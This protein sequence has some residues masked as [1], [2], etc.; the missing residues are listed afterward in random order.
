MFQKYVQ[1]STFLELMHS[2]NPILKRFAEPREDVVTDLML[3]NQHPSMR[4]RRSSSADGDRGER[5]YLM[6]L[7]LLPGLKN[8][9]LTQVRKEFMTRVG[10]KGTHLPSQLPG[11]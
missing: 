11:S 10:R 2:P 9:R 8:A 6:G 1:I 4:Q 7:R 3:S 5:S